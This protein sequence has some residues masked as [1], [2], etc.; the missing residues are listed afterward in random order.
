[1]RATT[2]FTENRCRRAHAAEACAL[3]SY[4]TIAKE[5]GVSRKPVR[6]RKATRQARSDLYELDVRIPQDKRSVFWQGRTHTATVPIAAR[7]TV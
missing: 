3:R 5:Q 4:S 1:M 7:D 6:T 2:S